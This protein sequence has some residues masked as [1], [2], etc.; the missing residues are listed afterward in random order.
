MNTKTPRLL[1]G[2]IVAPLAAPLVL[3]LIIMVS[4]EDL[5]GPSY[6]Y[7]FNDFMEIFGLAGMFLVLGAPIAYVIALVIGLPFYFIT[8]RINYINF[9]SITFGSAFVSIVPILI[10]SAPNGFVLYEDPEKSSILFYL[11]ISACGY[12]VGMVFWFIS[13]LHEHTAHNKSLNQT[14]ANNA[15]TG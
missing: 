5:R 1:L 11:A 2:C 9:W 6:E 4:G 10:M 3:L 12:V 15:P 14:G 13:G 7:G 8:E